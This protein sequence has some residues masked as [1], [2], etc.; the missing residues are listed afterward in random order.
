MN[1]TEFVDLAKK[2][3][4]ALVEK[5]LASDP[6]LAEAKSDGVSAVLWAVYCGHEPIAR[7]IA[8]AKSSLDIFEGAALGDEHVISIILARRP[9]SVNDYAAD[10]FTPLGL[11]A[12]FGHLETVKQLLRAGAD[13]NLPSKNRLGVIPLHSALANGSK[14]IARVLIE[15]GSDVNRQSKEGWTP[16]HYTAHNGDRETSEFLLSK[17]A[18]KTPVNSLGQTSAV[19]A[20]TNDHADLAGLLE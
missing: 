19:A 7:L 5:A 18:L 10:G 6:E 12:F 2:G 16:L 14:E 8:N 3:D 11:A 4:R 20:R 17:G 9:D 15:A 1:E 13:P